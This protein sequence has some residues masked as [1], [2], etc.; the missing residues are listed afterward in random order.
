M[1]KLSLF[2]IFLLQ[3]LS[4]RY[5]Y[6]Q[7]IINGRILGTSSIKSI[8][9]FN[10][11]NKYNNNLFDIKNIAIDKNNSFTIKIRSTESSFVNIYLPLGKGILSIYQRALD[12]VSFSISI[13]EKENKK[14]I[15][16]ID[17][18]GANAEGHR[19]YQQFKAICNQQFIVDN[20]FS[21]KQCT[22]I[23]EFI[24]NQKYKI[25]SIFK[26]YEVLENNGKIRNDFAKAVKADMTGFIL[27][28]TF[29]VFEYF[30]SQNKFTGKAV[31]KNWMQAFLTNR[32]LYTDSNFIELKKNAYKKY[33]PHDENYIMS[34]SVSLYYLTGYYQ[35]ILNGLIPSSGLSY[36][37]TFTDFA[38][39]PYY[40][41]IN[42]SILEF[43]WSV[44]LYWSPMANS[45]TKVLNKKIQAFKL[46]YPKSPFL[47]HL[48]DRY[49]E[50]KET[51]LPTDIGTR[52]IINRPYNKLRDLT[53]VE[54][55]NKFVF[56]DLWATWCTPCIEDFKYKHRI[57]SLL[58]KYNISKLYVSLDDS[59]RLKVWEKFI[60]EKKLNGYHF[61]ANDAFINNLKVQFN[62]NDILIPRYLLIDS[63][64]NIVNDDL[65]RPSDIEKLDKAI[66]QATKF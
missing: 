7:R 11:I 19:L 1:R 13:I 66:R 55:K 35:D 26:A 25:D 37:T 3:L 58:N 29:L 63:R 46:K 65:P 60:K 47:P 45:D 30:V 50:F 59:T 38:E 64:G 20:F 56:V 2:I 28:N 4:V 42:K 44:N 40:G 27:F 62:I 32:H 9:F 61:M 48:I 14:T 49:K 53:S 17:F 39:Y 31:L 33:N 8:S 10:P 6:S 24:A 51:E 21:N 52:K 5:V 12:T 16:R 36:D 22:N 18:Y 23:V 15:E 57:D 54:F 41:Y 34:S 43:I